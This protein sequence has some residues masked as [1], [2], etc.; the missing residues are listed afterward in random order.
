[1]LVDDVVVGEPMASLKG[2][3]DVR[4]WIAQMRAVAPATVARTG[5]PALT[6][7]IVTWDWAI[8]GLATG[9]SM[10]RLT[11]D[12]RFR[13]VAGFWLTAPPGFPTSV[14]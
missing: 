8:E 9:R 2:V 1:M 14:L 11:P 10:A 3:A 7:D 12:G 4:A 13:W 6:S 5:P